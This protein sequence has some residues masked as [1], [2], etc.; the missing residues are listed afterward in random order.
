MLLVTNALLSSDLT[1][2]FVIIV[3]FPK[4]LS[5]GTSTTAP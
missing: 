1:L 2:S 4:F 3:I 5:F